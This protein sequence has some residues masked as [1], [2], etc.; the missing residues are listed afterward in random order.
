MNYIKPNLECNSLYGLCRSIIINDNKEVVCY[1]PP[2]SMTY[3]FFMEREMN[4]DVVGMEFIEGTMINVFWHAETWDFS[5]K[6]VL[7]GKNKFYT[8]AKTFKMMFDDACKETNLNI[9]TLDKTKCYSFVLQ[10][11]ENRIVIPY[12]KPHLY[13]ISVYC[14][15]NSFDELGVTNNVV[16]EHTH[17]LELQKWECWEKTSIKFPNI[18]DLSKISI[19]T[20]IYEHACPNGNTPFD[21]VGIIFYNVKTGN[22]TKVRNITYEKVKQLRGNQPTLEYQYLCL[23]QE[24]NVSEFLKYYP[25]T[26]PYITICRN[27]LHLF[28]KDLFTNY[29][30]CFIKKEKK[31]IEYSGKHKCHMYNLHKLYTLELKS[32][33]CI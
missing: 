5:T 19:S 27:K 30:S 32:K 10:H 26:K 4:E 14:I 3:D 15:K 20:M 28:T 17:P 11:P 1:S 12:D 6:S 29:I 31:L 9:E 16:I 24:N 7:G 21:I 22:R 18:F 23:R 8:N 25:E 2:K 13:L 33:K